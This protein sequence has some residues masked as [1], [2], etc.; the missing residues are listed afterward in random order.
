M[1]PSYI[2][3]H[4]TASSRKTNPDQWKA[5]DAYHK[6]KGWG[7]GGYNYEIAANGSLHQFRED[8]T[9]TAAQYQKNMN[10]GRAIS[11][12]LDGFFDTEQ[13]EL[14]TPEQMAAVKKLVEEKMLK[15]K[16]PKENI[17]PHRNVAP[18]TCPGSAIPN[19]LITF[20]KINTN[21]DLPEFV[22]SNH[23]L[24]AWQKAKDSNIVTDVTKPQ[25]LVTTENLMVFLDRLNLLPEEN[26]LP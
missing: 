7:G 16:I 18:K 20:F 17:L 21:A 2:F 5:T 24:V 11:I 6:L 14:P 22:V 10:D 3:I 1:I 4:H 19:D 26:I 9:E 23:A 13:N 25:A 12:C 8:G 15:Y